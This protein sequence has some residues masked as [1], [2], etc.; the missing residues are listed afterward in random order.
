MK[1]LDNIEVR[2]VLKF[3]VVGASGV[4]V[5]MGL[6][7]LGVGV[8]FVGSAPSLRNTLASVVAVFVSIGT[9]FVVNDLW[10]WRDRREA[11]WRAAISRLLRYYVVA[12]V[13]GGVQVGV[14]W[15][16]SIPLGLNEHLANLV[17][18]GAGIAINFFANNF[19]TFKKRAR[20]DEAEVSADPVARVN[21]GRA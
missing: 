12:G 16:L 20:L 1:W 18:I 10:T 3:G 17:G 7:A 5:N 21:D 2:R 13:A 19:W 9:N 8:L 4:G 11:G 15:L 14:M 6:F